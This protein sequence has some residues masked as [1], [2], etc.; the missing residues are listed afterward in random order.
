VRISLFNRKELFSMNHSRI[1]A[2]LIF[3]FAA[4]LTPNHAQADSIQILTHSSPQFSYGD[5]I[6]TGGTPSQCLSG[7]NVAAS[8]VVDVPDNFTGPLYNAA[9]LSY[10]QTSAVGSDSNLADLGAAFTFSNSVLTN[11]ELQSNN[12][13]LTLREDDYPSDYD[14][15]ALF[16]GGVLTQLGVVLHPPVSNWVSAVLLGP[17]CAAAAPSDAPPLPGKVSC[18]EPFDVGTGNM[19]L[20]VPDYATVGQNPLAFT[21]YYNSFSVPDTYAVALGANWRHSFDRYL[22]I[23]NPSAIYGAIAERETGQYVSFSSS[24]GVYTTDFDLDYSLTRSGSTWTL[25]A[26][27]DTVETYAQSGA[28]ATLQTI[29]RRNG[30]TQTMHYASGKLSS[31]TD[32]YGRTL[33][34]SYSSVG[35]LAT[36]TTPDTPTFTYGYVGYSSTG[37][38]LSTVTYNTSPTTHQTYSYGNTSYPTALTGITDENGHLYSSW[39]YES[40]G[41]IATSQLAGAVNFTSVTYDDTTGN[42]LVKGPLGIVET[43][44]FSTLQGVPVDFH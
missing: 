10:F 16:S 3:I 30:Y 6:A 42:R 25:T 24:S 37:H 34:L 31:V 33:G 18:G 35:L 14:E 27:D 32:T 1:L 26:P 40:S 23:I 41:R 17:S 8:V 39:T 38:L 4:A 13:T 15:G 36:V 5:C 20:T 28:E 12:F 9:V 7:G 22:H 19:Y 21:R 2:I 44:K 43:Y 11:G 29:K